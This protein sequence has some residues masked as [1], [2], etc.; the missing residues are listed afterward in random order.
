MKSRYISRVIF[1]FF[2]MK[3]FKDSFTD[4][5]L[6]YKMTFDSIDQ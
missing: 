4:K 2:L 1:F 3:N 6:I 5:F